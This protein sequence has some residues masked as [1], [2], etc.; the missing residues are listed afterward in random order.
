MGDRSR[1]LAL[2]KSVKDRMTLF[3][4]NSDPWLARSWLENVMD[5]F[6]YITCTEAEQ[7]ELAVFYLRDQAVTWWKTQRTILGD[8]SSSWSV[9]REAFEK[10]YFSEAFCMTQRQEFLN[11]K[12]GDRSVAEYHKQFLKLSEFCP[13]MVAQ[14][15]SRMHQFIQGLTASIR[16][17][18]SS[19]TV[20]T[21]RE[22]LDRALLIETTQ[23]Q[24]TQERDAEKSKGSSSQ[25]SG[26]KR[27]AQDSEY[28]DSSRRQ[29]GKQ[30][31]SEPWRESQRNQSR[32]NRCFR[33][34]SGSHRV[35]DCPL[36]QTIC[37]YCKQPGHIV[38]DCSLRAQLELPNNK[39][40]GAQSIQPRPSKVQPRQIHPYQQKSLQPS[41]QIYQLHGREY[42]ALPATQPPETHYS[43]TSVQQHLPAISPSND[44]P[45]HYIHQSA[46]EP[47]SRSQPERRQPI[48][49]SST[50][51]ANTE[52]R[53]TE[54]T[55]R[56]EA[57][58]NER[59]IN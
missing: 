11:L 52:V 49:Y 3:H 35:D 57:Q 14:D 8:R 20:T 32:N 46:S 50:P 26:Q 59:W 10:E 6:T 28:G 23:R 54:A 53:H 15:R 4:G 56:T 48:L 58:R 43:T 36:D 37:Y 19:C 47:Q 17:A 29:K 16:L 7:V 38:R 9:F 42:E 18:M 1:I 5:T 24:V 22:A 44:A 25:T 41:G 27:Q 39:P 31:S 21:Y 13:E 40:L 45:Y 51:S 55:T 33:C 2:A 34:G 12:Q 30:L